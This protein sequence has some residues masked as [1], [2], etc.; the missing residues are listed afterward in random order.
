MDTLKVLTRRR[1]GV[2]IR[3]MSAD[4]Q[5]G[6]TPKYNSNLSAS[7]TTSMETRQAIRGYCIIPEGDTYP[8]SESIMATSLA[9]FLAKIA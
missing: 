8:L 4:V 1:W 7:M 6:I 5:I 2:T 3:R 9:D